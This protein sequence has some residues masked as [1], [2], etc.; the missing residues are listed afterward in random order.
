MENLLGIQPYA[1]GPLYILKMNMCLIVS[2]LE[3]S[4]LEGNSD[5]ELVVNTD[6]R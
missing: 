6:W 4:D 1:F 3:D 2:D 5:S